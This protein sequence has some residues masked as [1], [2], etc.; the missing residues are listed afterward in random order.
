MNTGNQVNL[1]WTEIKDQ[2]Q[3]RLCLKSRVEIDNERMLSVREYISLC[4]CIS[5]Q[6]L[7]HDP[8]LA[9]DLHRIQLSTFLIFD[10][11]DFTETSTA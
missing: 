4:L 6:V 10:Q 8:F 5:Y 9:E 2:E 1:P 7:S 3:F 11:V